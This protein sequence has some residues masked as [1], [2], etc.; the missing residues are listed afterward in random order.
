MQRRPQN[1]T[2]SKLLLF[3]LS[4]TRFSITPFGF[5]IRSSSTLASPPTIHL[6]MHL[7]L[8]AC[9]KFD[10]LAKRSEIARASRNC[11]IVLSAGVKKR[12]AAAW[13]GLGL[14]RRESEWDA[15]CI[16]EREN[17][18]AAA[19]TKFRRINCVSQMAKCVWETLSW[20]KAHCW[21][22]FCSHFLVMNM[23]FAIWPVLFALYFEQLHLV[24]LFVPNLQSTE[25]FTKW[26]FSYDAAFFHE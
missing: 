23:K 2:G 26:Q 3:F 9:A 10:T 11:P 19:S 8:N 13:E 14:M 20:C 4:H 1:K 21:G 15:L 5:W 24:R 25:F 7:S 16:Y 12:R 18:R 22:A 17:V 6:L